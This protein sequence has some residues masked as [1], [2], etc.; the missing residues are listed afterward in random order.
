MN[1]QRV[2]GIAAL[3][4]LVIALFTTNGF[5]L[6]GRHS[7]PLKLYGNVDIREVD[8]AF[9][10]GGR[11]GAITVEEGEKVTVG[12]PLAT[13][14]PASI[15]AKVGQAD[16][17]VAQAQAQLA[18]LRNGSRAQ[19]IVQA[20][21]RAAAADATLREA[22]QDVAR[23]KD[24]VSSGAIS[25]DLWQQTLAIAERAKAQRDESRAG[26]S[27]LRAGARAEDIA[28]AEAQLR[29]AE[30]SRKSVTTDKGDTRLVAASAG[31]VATRAREPG[32]I[33]QGGE[34]VLTV[35]IDR[36]MRVRAYVSEGDLARVAPGM[37]VTVTAD[38]NPKSYHGTIGYISPKAEFTPKSV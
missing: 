23:R 15:D 5:G 14:D 22:Q 2:I 7:G 1:R 21:A 20:E 34:T 17:A 35:A 12:Q 27:L 24:L 30:A 36:P 29:S 13:L 32:A 16:A 4:A 28:A 10:V 31:T 18:K 38:G 26:L 6:I 25:R 8:M 19:D 3:A 9:R 11:I 37:K 33:V